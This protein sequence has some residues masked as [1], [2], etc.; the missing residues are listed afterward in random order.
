MPTEYGNKMLQDPNFPKKLEAV[1]KQLSPGEEAWGM[2]QQLASS[3][4]SLFDRLA[5]TLLLLL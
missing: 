2:F 5:E 4:S 1:L 3:L